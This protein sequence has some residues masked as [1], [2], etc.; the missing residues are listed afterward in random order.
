MVQF[1]P[2]AERGRYDPPVV[3]DFSADM[4]ADIQRRSRLFDQYQAQLEKNA[5]IEIEE[6]KN[7]NNYKGLETLAKFSGT[8]ATIFR[9]TLAKLLRISRKERIGN[10]LLAVNFN[11]QAEIAEDVA[12]EAAELNLKK[13]VNTSNQIEQTTG[14]P[15]LANTYYQR[16]KGI[17]AGLQNEISLLKQATN[18]YPQFLSAYRNSNTHQTLAVLKSLSLRGYVC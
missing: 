14:S 16:N 15:I 6:A 17:G 8:A 3:E 1:R 4:K 2:A 9:R 13:V 5:R 12:S 18:N 10:T 7:P 11:P